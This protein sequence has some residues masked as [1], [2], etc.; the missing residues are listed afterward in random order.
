MKLI[1]NSSVKQYIIQFL[2]EKNGEDIN[3]PYVEYGSDI[4]F[5]KKKLI[6][7]NVKG[8]KLKCSIPNGSG[9]VLIENKPMPFHYYYD[10]YMAI[11]KGTKEPGL[12]I[13]AFKSIFKSTMKKDNESVLIM[14]NYLN[15]NYHE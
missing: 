2:M 8:K 13:S 14:E 4:E 12:C 15:E 10:D 1:Y 7:E 6:I 9:Y 5:Y 3:N 11:Q